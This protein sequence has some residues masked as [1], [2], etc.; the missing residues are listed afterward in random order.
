MTRLLI[1]R[2]GE[3]QWNTEKRMQGRSDSPL[4]SHGIWQAQQL[5]RRLKDEKIDVI[6]SSPSPRAAR[7]A[8]ILKGSR[9]LQV[10][11]LDDIMEINLGDWEGRKFSE[12]QQL[13][14]EQ[15]TAFWHAPHLYYR[16]GLESYHQV[17]ERLVRAIKQIVEAHPD[18]TVLIVS[19]SVATKTLMAYFEGRP[20]ERVWDPPVMEP[21]ALN[22]I[23]ATPTGYRIVMHADVSH[24]RQPAGEAPARGGEDARRE[25]NRRAVS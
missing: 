4:T 23:E 24:T 20:L 5:A 21:T 13:F 6:Y 16:E 15:S 7:T 1:T 11:L 25:S 18:Q 3:T 17:Q 22:I 9:G 2:H 10:R 14:P 12:V 19:H 8:E